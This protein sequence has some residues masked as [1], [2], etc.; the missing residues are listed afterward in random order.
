MTSNTRTKTD[1]TDKKAIVLPVKKSPFSPI[2]QENRFTV[3]GDPS[4][5]HSL[6]SL[7]KL[8]SLGS[9]RSMGSPQTFVQAAKTPF[10]SKSPQSSKL[11][12]L[13]LQ[14]KFNI[15]RR[16]FLHMTTFSTLSQS[17]KLLIQP[18]L[19]KRLSERDFI[20]F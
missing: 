5:F 11:P 1:Y 15:L 18:K 2:S 19:Q 3:L 4:K 13:V 7:S 8:P 9:F 20:T 6:P 10:P 12:F 17:G 16:Q 14:P